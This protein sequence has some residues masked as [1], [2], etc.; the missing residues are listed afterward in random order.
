MQE[1]FNG[2]KLEAG[3]SYVLRNGNKITLKL[4]PDIEW[5][6]RV[7]LVNELRLEYDY[8]NTIAE[9]N[10]VYGIEDGADHDHD[11]VG[12]WPEDYT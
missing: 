1:E 7:Y 8:D 6:G 12:F 4:S 11:I 2:L 10:L 3:K 9:G 5:D